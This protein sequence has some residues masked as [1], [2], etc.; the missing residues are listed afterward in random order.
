MERNLVLLFV[1]HPHSFYFFSEN[2][3]LHFGSGKQLTKIRRKT[4]DLDG[5]APGCFLF[6]SLSLCFSF[7]FLFSVCGCLMYFSFLL[8]FLLMM[9]YNS[10]GV[11]KQ[12]M[13]VLEVEI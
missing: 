6:F 2:G 5:L 4:D 10:L 11:I 1:F 9:M 3:I 7:V 8:L 12:H 13:D